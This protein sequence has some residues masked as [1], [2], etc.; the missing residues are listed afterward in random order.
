MQTATYGLITRRVDH[1]PQSLFRVLYGASF[2]I[3][4]PQEDELLLLAGPKTSNTLPVHLQMQYKVTTR[5][6]NRDHC[7]K[8]LARVTCKR[9]FHGYFSV[10]QH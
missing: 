6:G 9:I 4:V 8:L 1:V 5:F 10:L 3:P 2:G 7:H